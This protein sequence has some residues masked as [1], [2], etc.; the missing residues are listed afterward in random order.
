MTVPVGNFFS[1]LRSLLENAVNAGFIS[2]QNLALLRIVDIDPTP[3]SLGEGPADEWGSAA[4]QALDNWSL[5]VRPDLLEMNSS[6][7]RCQSAAGF[8]FDWSNKGDAA[9]EEPK[10]TV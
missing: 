3:G 6:S 8:G 7:D 4:I 5:E 2:L 1:P 10:A 9:G